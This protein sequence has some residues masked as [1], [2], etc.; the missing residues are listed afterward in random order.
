MSNEGK[1]WWEAIRERAGP[2]PP[3]AFLFVQEGLHETSENLFDRE[4]LMSGPE[5]NRHV[6]GQQLCLGLRDYALRQYGLL[7]R[8]VLDH[9]NIRRTEDFG[10]IVFALVDAGLLRK[11]DQDSIEDFAGVYDFDEVFGRHLE[12]AGRPR[13][14][15]DSPGTAD[16]A[17]SESR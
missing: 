10:R 14:H 4:G 16:N 13:L 7:A 3:E 12:G 2:Y 8:T 17:A 6:T 1:S 9:W 15:Y 11:T 5:G